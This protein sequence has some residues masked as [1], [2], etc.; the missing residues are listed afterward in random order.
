[1]LDAGC[2]HPGGGTLALRTRFFKPTKAAY[3]YM[4]YAKH[5]ET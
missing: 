1:V 5:Y 3:P 4:V 2:P